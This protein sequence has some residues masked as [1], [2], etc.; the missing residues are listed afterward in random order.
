MQEE[1]N[2]L[3]VSKIQEMM[4][5][6]PAMEAMCYLTLSYNK[7]PTEKMFLSIR[8]F[9]VAQLEIENCQC[10]GPFETATLEEFQLAKKVDG[11]I[12][13]NVS[14]HKTYKLGPA[15][16]TMCDNTYSNVKAYVQYV[17]C[18]FANEGEET[19]FV[20]CEG[21]AFLSGTL[22]RRIKAWW[23]DTIGLDVTSTQRQR[24]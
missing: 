19:L 21:N 8:D 10:P 4:D 22:G 12:V 15:S 17:R 13:M 16:I 3:P 14:R 23:K 6:K 5:A 1:A 20:T 18:H 2:V 7:P 9:F 11:K 24:Q